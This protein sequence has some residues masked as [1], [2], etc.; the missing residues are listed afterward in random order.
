MVSGQL[1]W[2]MLAA[3][4]AGNDGVTSPAF[5]EAGPEVLPAFHWVSTGHCDCSECAGAW[6]DDTAESDCG[7]CVSNCPA[8]CP[9]G[10]R[11]TNLSA[12]L[13]CG[14]ANAQCGGCS[15]SQGRCSLSIEGLESSFNCQCG[16]SYNHPVPP[17]STYHWPGM[18]KAPSMVGWVSPWTR[19]GLRRA[20]D[21]VAMWDGNAVPTEI[22]PGLIEPISPEPF[23]PAPT[24]GASAKSPTMSRVMQRIYR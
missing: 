9:L 24:S 3:L 16:G 2:V 15:G 4:A 12:R 18:Y 23:L 5:F 7:D 6:A 22:E 17:L 10:W 8:R 14:S 19:P 13:R 20:R 21:V 1:A 11:V